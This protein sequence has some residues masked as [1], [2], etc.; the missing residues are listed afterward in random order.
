MAKKKNA[1]MKRLPISY[2]YAE[3]CRLHLEKLPKDF[4]GF[5]IIATLKIS[6]NVISV[7]DYVRSVPVS[8]IFLVRVFLHSQNAQNIPQNTDQKNSKYGQLRKVCGML[9]FLQI[10]LARLLPLNSYF[11]KVFEITLNL[12]LHFTLP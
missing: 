1:K 11:K 7:S 8:G 5:K 10:L 3:I 4:K 6:Q 12:Q 2:G 9:L